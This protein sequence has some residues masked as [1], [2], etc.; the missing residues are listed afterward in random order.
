[1]KKIFALVMG[2]IM[3][4]GMSAYAQEGK[5]IMATNPEFPPF[6]YVEGDAVVGFDADLAAEIAK[7]LGLE[8]QI[9][10]MAF[11]SI[12][13]A[14]QTGK[15]NVG[16]AGMSVKPDR[17]VSVDFSEAYFE[18]TQICIIK[19]G[20]AIATVEDLAG[21]L[22]G[23]QLG[24]TGDFLAETLSDKIEGSQKILDAVM[25]L[26]GGKLDAVIIDKPV[27]ENILKAL[28]DPTLK[29]VETIVFEPEFYAVAIGKNQPELLESINKTIA[30]IKEDGTLDALYG[31]YFGAKEAE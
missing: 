15:A 24:T 7:D 9:D 20:T 6:E 13:A 27:G 4:F 25:E 1:M 5:L 14:I 8:L 12:I 2:L 17:L 30:R 23:V 28:N 31:K 29:V 3:L 10:S 18:A 21:K 19:E 22:I 26:Q 16:I 11:D